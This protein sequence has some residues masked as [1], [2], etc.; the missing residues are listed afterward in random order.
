MTEADE[1]LIAE[2][3]PVA[4]SRPGA[5]ETGDLARTVMGLA[6][7]EEAGGAETGDL[8]L[9][10]GAAR[11]HQGRQI[12]R[13]GMGKVI[14]AEDRQFGRKVA[15]KVMLDERG[16]ERAQRFGLEAVITANLDH[17]GIPSVY[18]RGHD[19][20][21]RPFYAMRL[22]RGRSLEQAV[23]AARTLDE[24]L[25]LLPA[26]IDVAQTVAFAHA[27]GVIHRDLK[28]DNVVVG[29]YGD[30]VVIDWGVAKLRG[31][32]GTAALKPDLPDPAEAVAHSGSASTETRDGAVIGT[33][34]FMA[35]EQ[36][37]GRI[38]A[39]DERS[40][41]F[42]LGA[43]L[44]HLFTGR[45]PY[46][47]KTSLAALTLA[48]EADYQPLRQAAPEVPVAIAA[49]VDRAMALRP[50]DRFQSAGAL[51][52]ALQE[53][54]ATGVR[55]REAKAVRL[56]ANTTGALLTLLLLGIVAVILLRVNFADLGIFG[57]MMLPTLVLGI[58]L[59]AIEWWTAGRHHLSPIML[60]LVVV[61]GL[62]GVIAT[63]VGRLEV[64]G[65]LVEGNVAGTEAM[66]TAYLQGMRIA[67]LPTVVG[68]QFAAAQ[69]VLWAMARYRT[70]SAK[71]AQG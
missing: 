11:Y 7:Q 28:P 62:E 39:I 60:A 27:R 38:E 30:T 42:S 52:E 32:P 55:G 5:G 63:T 56:F 40:D 68:L 29:A 61:T 36:A 46:A 3:R 19:E 43:M 31:V 59:S 20:Q 57:L 6:E 71:L 15:L 70:L 66:S 41:V 14:E 67:E 53:V 64:Y 49:I 9:P 21:G 1:T 58:V 26:L 44:Y 35:P 37:A 18:E 54:V 16:G 47:G 12:G 50:E 4:A 23:A 69:F 22:I 45:P 34:A 48:L 17:P 51:A 65:V 10:V 33:P 8:R 24:R 25:R 2:D 13:G